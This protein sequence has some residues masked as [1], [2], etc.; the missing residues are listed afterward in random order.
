MAQAAENLV[1][2]CYVVFEI[3]CWTDI[4]TRWL[5]AMLIFVAVCLIK[6][7]I[8]NMA[9]KKL[10]MLVCARSI[11]DMVNSGIKSVL[12][13]HMM[14]ESLVWQSAINLAKKFSISWVYCAAVQLRW[15]LRTRPTDA[16]KFT[17]DT[18]AVSSLTLTAVS[19]PVVLFILFLLFCGTV[20]FQAFLLTPD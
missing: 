16:A 12:E 10:T 13:C 20:N 6:K 18:C 14:G 3:S 15:L 9:K 8:A 7:Y 19:F 5:Q 1:K 4:R 17:I 11:V 2:F